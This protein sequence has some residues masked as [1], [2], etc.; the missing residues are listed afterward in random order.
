VNTEKRAMAADFHIPECATNSVP[1]EAG[2][3]EGA[4][5]EGTARSITLSCAGVLCRKKIAQIKT[6]GFFT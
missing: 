2:I 3:H 1:T 4:K 5:K 6:A